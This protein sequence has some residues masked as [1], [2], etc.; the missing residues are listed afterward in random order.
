MSSLVH[1]EQ[2]CVEF[3]GRRVLDNISMEL[4]K[5]KITTLIGPNGAGKSTLVKVILGLQ[6]PTSG[7]LNRQ[8]KLKIGYV[9]QKLKLNDSLPLNVTRF[10]NLA[11]KY[12]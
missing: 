8:R 7:K 2:L 10:L 5:G 11:G 3:D 1:L 9:P 12:S 4:E 6:K